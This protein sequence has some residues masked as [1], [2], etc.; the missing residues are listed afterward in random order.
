MIRV[1]ETGCLDER[2]LGMHKQSLFT[3]AIL[4]LTGEFTTKNLNFF[5]FPVRLDPN[6]N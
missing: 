3:S 5:S 6:T 4:E 1:D 2:Q